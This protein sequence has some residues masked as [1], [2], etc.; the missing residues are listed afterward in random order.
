MV[1]K[2][3]KNSLLIIMVLSIMMVSFGVYAVESSKPESHDA[4]WISKHGVKAKRNSA[5]CYACHDQKLECIACHQDTKPRSHNLSWVNKTHGM[6]ARWNKKSC[7]TCHMEDS[8]IACHE[9]MMPS[10]HTVNFRDVHCNTGCQLPVG[11]WKNTIS[12]DCVVCHIRKPIP[13]H[14]GPQ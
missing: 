12:K 6:E 14:A 10:N 9:T 2:M 11:R 8:C 7:K 5:D 4:N 13:T 1:M 3:K